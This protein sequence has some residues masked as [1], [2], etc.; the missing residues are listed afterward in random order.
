[1]FRSV[2]IPSEIKVLAVHKEK[3]K[4][5]KSELIVD[6]DCNSSN[7]SNTSKF[8]CPVLKYAKSQKYT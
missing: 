6:D 2:E 1:M 8:A 5:E 7:S 4:I 3:K